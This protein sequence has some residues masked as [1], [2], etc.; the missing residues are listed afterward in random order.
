VRLK[1]P[2]TDFVAIVADADL[3]VAKALKW[4]GI[5]SLE[6][7]LALSAEDVSF[8]RNVGPGAVQSLRRALFRKN[9]LLRN[10][11][12]TAVVTSLMVVGD[13]DRFVAAHL[14]P[15]PRPIP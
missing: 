12:I 13:V 14:G 4:K 11:R 10:D 15:L 7:L 2:E 9:L 6:K 8:F 1:R 5:D 3:K